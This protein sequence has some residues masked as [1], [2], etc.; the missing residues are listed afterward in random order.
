MNR[1]AQ[2]NKTSALMGKMTDKWTGTDRQRDRER[3]ET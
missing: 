2:I 3:R 1:T